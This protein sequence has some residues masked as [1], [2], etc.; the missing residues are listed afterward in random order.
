MA[1]KGKHGGPRPNS[2]RPTF[3]DEPMEHTSIRIPR[4]Y[5]ELLSAAGG[6]EGM[7]GAVRRLVEENEDALK[8]WKDE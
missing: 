6:R 8:K 7:S 1:E 2:G 3:Y 4:Q 5:K